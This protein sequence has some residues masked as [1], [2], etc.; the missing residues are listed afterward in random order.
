MKFIK[1]KI[2]SI[3]G[4]ARVILISLFASFA[5]A[6]IIRAAT[7]IG[8]NIS[9]GGTLDVTGASTL[10]GNTSVNGSL[11]TSGANTFYGVTSIGGALTATS[12]LSVTATSTLSNAKFGDSMFIDVDTNNIGVF[13]LVKNGSMYPNNFAWA[14]SAGTSWSV[15]GGKASKT[16][17]DTT[18]LSQSLSI[19]SGRTYIVTY[20]LIRTAG[21]IKATLGGTDGATRSA[22]GRYGEE[23]IPANTNGTIMFTPSSDFAGSVDEIRVTNKNMKGMWLVGETTGDSSPNGMGLLELYG[24][25][26]TIYPC[27]YCTDQNPDSPTYGNTL[28]VESSISSISTSTTEINTVTNGYFQTRFEPPSGNMG[29][30]GGLNNL[31]TSVV[32]NSAGSLHSI[33]SIAGQTIAFSEGNTSTATYNIENWKGLAINDSNLF[34]D[35]GTFNVTNLYDLYLSD[36]DDFAKGTTGTSTGIWLEPMTIGTIN[37]GIVLDG[38]GTGSDIVF[39]DTQQIGLSRNSSTGALDIGGDLNVTTGLYNNMKLNDIGS[40]SVCSAWA[41]VINPYA[42]ASWLTPATTET[43]MIG[44]YQF[45]YNNITTSEITAKSQVWTLA[46]TGGTEYISR[47]DSGSTFSFIDTGSNGFSGA[48]WVEV[49]DQGSAQTIIAKYGTAGNREWKFGFDSGGNEKL[50]LELYDQSATA[51]CSKTSDSAISAGWHLLG[52][53]Y[54]GTAASG[55]ITFYDNGVAIA[56]TGVDC[57]AAGYVS[58]EDLGQTVTIGAQGQP[59]FYLL[60]DMGNWMLSD[61]EL[62]ADQHLKIYNASKM[63]YG[64]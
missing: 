52:F 59:L 39:G 15:G 49:T 32:L 35:S 53:T 8:T 33:P 50:Y 29:L 30:T 36:M 13:D 42:C 40:K 55:G 16:A 2:L 28:Y 34:R 37:H 4:V 9:T 14:I 5:C 6:G 20:K 56:A 58:M 7:T 61:D 23:I 44:G 43:D 48:A 19:V 21:S 11:T 25:H 54:D 22:S 51:A 46:G 63:F 27:T 31:S 3:K 18:T 38:N 47:A 60:G 26:S 57:A 41:S 12:T 64:T 10:T 45:T 62:T 24:L 17:G 1:D